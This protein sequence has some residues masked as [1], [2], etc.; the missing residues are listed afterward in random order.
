MTYVQQELSGLDLPVPEREQDRTVPSQ[1]QILTNALRHAHPWQLS[2]SLEEQALLTRLEK[3]FPLLEEVGCTVGIGVAT[4]CDAIL[5][6]QE[7]ALPIE[8]SRK[9]PRRKERDMKRLADL[10]I[11]K[12]QDT[13]HG[14]RG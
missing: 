13:L 4:G 12:P 5:I 6:G 11:C 7:E 3:E 10:S 8:A 2:T 1:V 9:L 14:G